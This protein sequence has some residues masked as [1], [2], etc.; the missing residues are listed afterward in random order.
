[1]V[2]L[3]LNQKLK[4]MISEMYLFGRNPSNAWEVDNGKG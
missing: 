3:V 1:M 4:A 2:N